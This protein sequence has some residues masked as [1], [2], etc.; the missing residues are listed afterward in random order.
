MAAPRCGNDPPA[1]RGRGD[2][3]RPIRLRARSDDPPARHPRRLESDRRPGRRR[4]APKACPVRTDADPAVGLPCAWRARRDGPGSRIGRPW[5]A[6]PWARRGTTPRAPPY[7]PE[8]SAGARRATE[9]LRA[10]GGRVP[11]SQARVAARRLREFGQPP[12]WSVR[13]PAP[14][15][16]PS[17]A[18][19]RSPADPRPLASTGR[20]GSP[21]RRVGAAPG[22]AA[23][24]RRA[25]YG[26]TPGFPPG[27][28]GGV[29][30][31]GR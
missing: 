8:R 25:L 5:R 23:A 14:H 26:R 29:L 16:R 15:A 6:W 28:A 13:H 22:D 2:S 24:P 7:R 10:R 20:A 18:G 31:R 4:R 17:T 9:R 3:P 21:V 30:S 27:P 1:I 11:S 12:G 19:R